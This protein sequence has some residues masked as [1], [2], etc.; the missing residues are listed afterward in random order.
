MVMVRGRSS[1][2][3]GHLQTFAL[4]PTVLKPELNVLGFKG[5]EFLPVGHPV[6]IVSIFEDE[7]VRRVGVDRKPLLQPRHL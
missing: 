7:V 5:W 2:E 6:E 4:G 3:Q 1:F